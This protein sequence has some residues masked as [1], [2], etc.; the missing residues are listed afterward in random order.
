MDANYLEIE[1]A[2]HEYRQHLI[3]TD[4]QYR[5]EFSTNLRKL[6]VLL[7]A[8]ATAAVIGY[9]GSQPLGMNPELAKI[10]VALA[11]PSATLWIIV[12]F[13]KDLKDWHDL[14]SEYNDRWSDE[15]QRYLDRLKT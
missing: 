8:S 9:L 6:K 4:F 10:L 2:T 12:D 11:S 15:Y 1:K 5:K 7:I 13:V 3:T 14:W